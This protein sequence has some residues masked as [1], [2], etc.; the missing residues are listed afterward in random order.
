MVVSTLAESYIHLSSQSA[1]GAAEATAD[2]KM[3]KYADLPATHIFQPLVFKTRGATH[4][5]ALDFLNAVGGR[6][7][8]ESGDPEK[9]LFFYRG[10]MPF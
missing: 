2:I 8:A 4:S 9:H 10:S 1:G 7:A 5:S 3:S 6:S